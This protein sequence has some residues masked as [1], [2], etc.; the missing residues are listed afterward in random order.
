MKVYVFNDNT[1][2]LDELF[3]GEPIHID[4]K[5]YLRDKSGNKKVMDIFEANDYRG[6]YK[7]VP[8]DGSGKML[9][10]AKYHKKVK[11]IPIDAEQKIEPQPGHLCMHK[12]C[13]HVSPSPEELEAHTR[14]KHPNTETL[15][16]PDQD[17]KL[18]RKAVAK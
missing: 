18:N 7:A 2:P 16:L 5:D 3:K 12:G 14:V 4:P 10:D 13:S 9:D 15:S 8:F 6:Q 11:L 1:H 17:V